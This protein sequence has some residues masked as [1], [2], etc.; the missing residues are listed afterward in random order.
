VPPPPPPPPPSSEPQLPDS[1]YQYAIVLDHEIVGPGNW[2]L[3]WELFADPWGVN[4]KVE[5][6]A[7][8]R[9]IGSTTM[10]IHINVD[11]AD[12]KEQAKIRFTIADR[13]NPSEKRDAP[14][15]VGP[16]GDMGQSYLWINECKI[17]EDWH[18]DNGVWKRRARCGFFKNYGDVFKT[19]RPIF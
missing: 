2:Q 18:N 17:L 11:D 13:I 16:N 9:D 15:Y 8:Y 1:W 14:W 7:T 5:G 12:I 10:E 3:T 6:P 4:V 19:L